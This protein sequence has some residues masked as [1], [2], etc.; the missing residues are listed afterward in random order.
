MASKKKI[1]LNQSPGKKILKWYLNIKNN[2]EK[3]L[4]SKEFKKLL[5]KKELGINPNKLE[6]IEHH[7]CHSY[8]SICSENELKN[9]KL[10]F[11]VD[12]SGDKGINAT[13]SIIKNK[14][15]KRIFQT[16]NLIIGRIY[17]HVTL[18]LGMKWGEHEYK[19]MGLAPY[20][21]EYYS[22]GPLKIFSESLKLNL[23]KKILIS[24]KLKTA[25][26]RL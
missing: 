25:I 19:T 10:V 2:K 20:S 1:D 6:C 9:N 12:G 16:K 7:E 26:F 11:T 23:N 5:I 21:S 13:I 4:F 24:K 15:L 8:Y 22:D 17:R 14:K 18:I 3:K